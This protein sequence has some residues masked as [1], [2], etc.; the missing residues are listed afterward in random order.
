VEP[1]TTRSASTK[2]KN[3]PVGDALKMLLGDLNFAFVPEMKGPSEL[4]VFRTTMRNATQRV[5]SCPKAKHVANELLVKVKSGTDIKALAKIVGAKVTGEM[6]KY[7]VYQLQFADADATEAALAQLQN[8][9]DVQAVDYNYYFDQPPTAQEVS[10][11]PTTPL[12]LTLNPPPASGK[13]IV[14][15]ID[16]SV[17]TQALGSD[18]AQFI[19]SQINV[20]DGTSSDSG[21]TWPL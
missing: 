19:L 5:V 20:A 16:T 2:F 11:A 8:N 7:G 1:G 14:G 3:L 17:D 15:L 13:T 21:P 9:S 18:A 6:D 12:S 4:Y 10:S